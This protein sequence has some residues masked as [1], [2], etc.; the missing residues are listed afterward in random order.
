MA[1]SV[2]NFRSPILHTITDNSGDLGP[3]DPADIMDA[4]ALEDLCGTSTTS[5][6]ERLTVDENAENLDLM[7]QPDQTEPGDQADATG[8]ESESSVV[9]DRFPFGRPGAPIRDSGQAPLAYDSQQATCMGSSWGPFRSQ[10]DWDVAHWVKLC[11]LSSTAASKL[12]AIPGVRAYNFQFR[13]SNSIV[14]GC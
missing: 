13:V 2:F 11:G 9:V 6:H 1:H 3:P 12:L 14:I 7:L 4:D 5:T 8:S 10:L